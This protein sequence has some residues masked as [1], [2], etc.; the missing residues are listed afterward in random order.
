MSVPKKKKP[1]S[2]TRKGRSHLALKKRL[3]IKCPQCG[4]AKEPHHACGFC[5]YYRGRPTLKLNKNKTNK[6]KKEE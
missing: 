1:K 3:L 5:G 4:H 2:A 6:K